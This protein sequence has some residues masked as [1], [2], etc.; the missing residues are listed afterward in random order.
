[1]HLAHARCYTLAGQVHG[2]EALGSNL[3]IIRKK[4]RREVSFLLRCDER[5]DTLRRVLASLP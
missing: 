3:G 4:R 1:V 5:R 2:D